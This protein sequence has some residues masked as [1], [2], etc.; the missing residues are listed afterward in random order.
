MNATVS[1][2]LQLACTALRRNDRLSKSDPCVA[3]YIQNNEGTYSLAGQTETI[4]NDANPRFATTVR[5][6][7]VPL[8]DGAV[9][10]AVYDAD[11]GEALN[12]DD[13][14]GV[15]RLTV[16][17]LQG[18]IDSAPLVDAGGK[19]ENDGASTITIVVSDR[20]I[21]G[22]TAAATATTEVEVAGQKEFPG[23]WGAP[24]LRQTRDYVEWPGG[25]G[26][27]SGTVAA[28]I[29]RKM[30]A[31]KDA[32]D[33]ER[34]G[35]SGG[36]STV[37]ADKDAADGDDDGASTT[38]ESSVQ[39]QVDPLA[40]EEAVVAAEA[41]AAETQRLTSAREMERTRVA[42]SRRAS[43]Q[44]DAAAAYAR[45]VGSVQSC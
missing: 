30:Q 28:W 38:N 20:V 39:A 35:D 19:Q 25:Y 18:T 31:D 5:V 17:E 22:G 24:P 13:L 4:A 3:V 29:R 16:G 36:A 10:F 1:A 34:D 21:K 33:K 44:R 6:T 2:T 12:E 8:R 23:H 27:G 41:M 37:E 9:K 43:L 26:Q 7:D 45:Q 42:V 11:D 15:L 14:L 32:A 40:E